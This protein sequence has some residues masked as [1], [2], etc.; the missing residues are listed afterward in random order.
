MKRRDAREKLLSALYRYPIVLGKNISLYHAGG[1]GSDFFDVDRLTCNPESQKALSEEIEAKVKKLVQKGMH[2]DK[3]AFI[4]KESGPVGIIL[5]ASTLSQVFRKKVIILRPWSKLKLNHI[6]VKGWIGDIDTNPI[7]SNDS[8]L[9]VDD[10]ITTGAIQ[11]NAIEI[12]ERYKAKVTGLVCVFARDTQVVENIK[13]EKK[14]KYFETIWNYDELVYRGLIMAQPDRLLEEDF[15]KEF[16]NRV[17]P[18]ER[19]SQ[20]EKEINAKL[21]K[22]ISSFLEEENISVDEPI[23]LGLKNLLFNSLLYSYRE[24]LVKSLK[25]EYERKVKR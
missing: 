16:A 1:K 15:V 25:H 8:I 20:A 7:E 19:V 3:M 4:D 10:V 18:K 6:K 13:R 12:A 22:M 24:R 9:L 2:F 17:L 11:K 21:E 23:K 5:L 14:I